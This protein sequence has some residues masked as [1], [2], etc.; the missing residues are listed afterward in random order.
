ME[1]IKIT[2]VSNIFRNLPENTPSTLSH[3]RQTREMVLEVEGHDPVRII[4]PFCSG[5]KFVQEGALTRCINLPCNSVF[6][7]MSSN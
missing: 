7:L 3:N 2:E 6:L 1:D 4:C 5:T